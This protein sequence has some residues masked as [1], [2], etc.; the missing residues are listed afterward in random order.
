MIPRA[1]EQFS[2]GGGGKEMRGSVNFDC[3][4]LEMGVLKVTFNV[5]FKDALWSKVKFRGQG[6]C[7]M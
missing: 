2:S 1:D 4:K 6:Q 7:S 5:H 3:P